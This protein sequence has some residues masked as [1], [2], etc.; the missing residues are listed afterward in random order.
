MKKNKKEQIDYSDIP[1]TDA[2]FWKDAEVHRPKGKS[3]KPRIN[4]ITLGTRNLKMATKFYEHGLGFPKMNFEGNVSFFTLNGSWLALYP[5]E[6][7]AED[8]Q[9]EPIG[10]GFRG[11]TLAHNVETEQQV[12]EL[13]QNAKNSG[14]TIVKPAQKTDWGGFSGYFSDLDG[15]LWEISHN[16]FFWPGPRDTEKAG[17]ID[18]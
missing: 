8:A 9:I 11:F 2:N 15:H 12:M 10:S 3:M 4:I 6:L 17:E 1:E 7:L 13:L 18:D 5:W 14:A 16:P